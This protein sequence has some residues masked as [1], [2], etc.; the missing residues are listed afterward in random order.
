MAFLA[1]GAAGV[2]AAGILKPLE[3]RCSHRNTMRRARSHVDG[4]RCILL[5]ERH[6]PCPNR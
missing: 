2:Q 4:A 5:L 3:P 1:M 6:F